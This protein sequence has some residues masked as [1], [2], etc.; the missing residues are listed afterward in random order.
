MQEGEASREEITVEQILPR[1]RRFEFRG[2]QIFP[3]ALMSARHVKFA[4]PG[5]D[6][7]KLGRKLRSHSA[8]I[9]QLVEHNLAKVGVASSN[10]VSRSTLCNAKPNTAYLVV[11][12]F[13][14][15]VRHC[16][17]CIFKRFVHQRSRKLPSHPAYC[18]YGA[19][20]PHSFNACPSRHG[21]PSEGFGLQWRK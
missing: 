21:S 19:R 10:L 12:K 13:I 1:R 18:R 14:D 15:H 4:E 11:P 2:A 9:A 8:G 6:I 16:G 3:A 20:Q 5:V 7:P 17:I